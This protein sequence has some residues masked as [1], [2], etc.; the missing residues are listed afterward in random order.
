MTK[1]TRQRLC[2]HCENRR[3]RI[4]WC[5]R[6]F[7]WA[8]ALPNCQCTAHAYYRDFGVLCDSLHCR[9]LCEYAWHRHRTTR[10]HFDPRLLKSAQV[11]PVPAV[12][13]EAKTMWR[14]VTLSCRL[15]AYKIDFYLLNKRSM[16][17]AK[18]HLPPL[19]AELIAFTQKQA[20]SI[21]V[22]VE[23]SFQGGHYRN[24]VMNRFFTSEQTKS[25]SSTLFMHSNPANTGRSILEGMM[26]GSFLLKISASSRSW[27]W[28]G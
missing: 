3:Y 7:N 17:I 22:K 23:G 11:F 16:D 26:N 9:L 28:S 15:Q 2:H 10:Q 13:I 27:C 8:S 19:S 14:R 24:G 4:T 18:L 12:V 1:V 21:G 6:G 5:S 20:V 25:T